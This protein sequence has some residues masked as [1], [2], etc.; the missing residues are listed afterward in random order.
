[1]LH[2]NLLQEIWCIGEGRRLK[3]GSFSLSF[4]LHFLLVSDNNNKTLA[5]NAERLTYIRRTAG[6]NLEPKNNWS[7]KRNSSSFQGYSYYQITTPVFY[8]QLKWMPRHRFSL[9][10]VLIGIHGGESGCTEEE[11]FRVWVVLFHS[12]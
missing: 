8:F 6:I 11:C 9:S 4:F 5:P 12:V 1:M 2:I 3:N 10:Q 7:S